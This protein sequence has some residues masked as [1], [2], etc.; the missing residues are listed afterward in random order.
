MLSS[1][2]DYRSYGALRRTALMV[3]AYNHKPERLR[4]LRDEFAEFDTESNGRI[5]RNEMQ[6][7]LAQ[8]G[9]AHEEIEELF[10]SLDL[11]RSG[12]IHYLE[13]LAATIEAVGGMEEDRLRLAF[14]RLD[15]DESGFITVANLKE[16]V[17]PSYDDEAIRKTLEEADAG[18]DGRVGWDEFLVLMRDRSGVDTI[19]EAELKSTC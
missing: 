19:V 10:K 8:R 7:A 11:D 18:K 3:V 13:F 9:V 2:R 6:A 5:S 14:E 4:E 15:T 12:D 16:I 1:M 17:G